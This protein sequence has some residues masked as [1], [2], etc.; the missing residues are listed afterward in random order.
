MNA[1]IE[2]IW[3]DF[4]QELKS[5]VVSKVGNTYDAEDIIQNAFLKI[6]QHQTKVQ[7]AENLRQYIYGIVRNATMDHFRTKKIVGVEVDEQIAFTEED[8]TSLNTKIAECCIMPFIHKLPEKYKEALL[9][10]EFQ[11]VS[12]KELAEKLNLS[13][14]GLKSRVQRGR[15]KLKQLLVDC[16]AYKSDRYGNIIC[17]NST[18]FDC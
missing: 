3:R 12:Q 1:A 18:E 11:D 4:H 2:V 17:G 8:E 7:S 9:I 14:S 10:I 16:C 5:F 13:H 15:E 6:I